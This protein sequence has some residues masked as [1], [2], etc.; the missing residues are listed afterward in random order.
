[1]IQNL[2][3]IINTF[4]IAVRQHTFY[5]LAAVLACK[6][7]RGPRGY[8]LR[9]VGILFI[10]KQIY[11]IITIVQHINEILKIMGKSQIIA[12]AISCRFYLGGE[13]I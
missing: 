4:I 8:I 6:Q 9:E 7:F 3:Y 11:D 1:M 2:D 12:S 13:I 10:I 5:F